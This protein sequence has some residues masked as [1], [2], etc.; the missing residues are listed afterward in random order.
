[1]ERAQALGVASTMRSLQG[2]RIL[3]TEDELLVAMYLEDML[4]RF[5]CEVVG[6]FATVAEAVRNAAEKDLDGA[7]LDINLRGESVFPAAVTLLERGV[8]FLFCSGYADL[9]ILPDRFTACPRISKPYTEAQ[10]RAAME[11]ALFRD[12]GPAA[13][14]SARLYGTHAP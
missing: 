1:M 3:A 11:R 10:L 5:G 14:G 8:P 2:L 13:G 6:P 4:S 9:S 12:K 7:V